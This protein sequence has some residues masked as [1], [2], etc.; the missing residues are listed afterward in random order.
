MHILHCV[1]AYFSFAVSFEG[2]EDVESLW[3]LQ[4]Y[5]QSSEFK[6]SV[7]EFIAE[8]MLAAGK[9]GSESEATTCPIGRGATPVVTSPSDSPLQFL[10]KE[11]NFSKSDFV[12]R[13]Q[14]SQGLHSLGERHSR[15]L[16][17]GMVTVKLCSIMLIDCQDGMRGASFS[18][19]GHC[20][21]LLT[22]KTLEYIL[23]PDMPVAVFR[24]GHVN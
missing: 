21:C 19:S 6:R 16:S 11:L 22:L 2:V 12:D 1:C 18:C 8:E 9:E 10:Y 5:G 3:Y 24:K 13:E 15:T 20:L 17:A 23:H 14:I 7:L 4:R